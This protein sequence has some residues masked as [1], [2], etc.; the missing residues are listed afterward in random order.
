M[1]KASANRSSL[2]LTRF[3]FFL[4]ILSIVS[5]CT[6]HLVVSSVLDPR[7]KELR[8]LN[9]QKDQLVEENRVLQQEIAKMSSLSVVTGRAEKELG[10]EKAD[11]VIYINTPSV[12]ANMETTSN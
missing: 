5:F 2:S 1:E 8:M 7:G 11:D 10:M 12:S 3:S 4:L 9:S 6:V